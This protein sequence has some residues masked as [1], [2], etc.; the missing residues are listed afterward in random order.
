[1]SKHGGI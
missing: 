1:M